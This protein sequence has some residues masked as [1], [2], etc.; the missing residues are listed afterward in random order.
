[1][2]TFSI[3]TSEPETE[4][5]EPTEE[6]QYELSE[7]GEMP[8]TEFK[9]TAISVVVLA[10]DAVGPFA[11]SR[12][13]TPCFTT[14]AMQAEHTSLLD[15]FIRPGQH[16]AFTSRQILRG[17]KAEADWVGSAA[18]RFILPFGSDGVC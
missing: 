13:A 4:E 18:D 9:P 17:V 8:V 3:E 1:M 5:T 16:S 12:I 7:V 10:G 6:T 15:K 2:Q 11:A 14:H